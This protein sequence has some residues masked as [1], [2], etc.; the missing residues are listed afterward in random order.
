[1]LNETIAINAIIDDLRW[2]NRASRRLPSEDDRC[3]NHYHICG[4]GVV[5]QWQSGVGSRLYARPRINSDDAGKIAILSEVKVEYSLTPLGQT[6]TEV[7][8]SICEWA[9]VH[10]DEIEAA[11]VR[12]DKRSARSNN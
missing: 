6:L 9:G 8:E 1:M 2:S 4:S 3:R 10:W 12:Y 5:L 7:L 11:R